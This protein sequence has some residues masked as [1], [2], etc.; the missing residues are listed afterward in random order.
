LRRR[1]IRT[2]PLERGAAVAAALCLS[3]CGSD[4]GKNAVVPPP[5]LPPSVASALAAR[6]DAVADALAAGDSCRAAS[7]AT[8]LQRETIAAINSGRVAG[9]L[10]EPLSTS[11]ND[12][13]A[14][15]RCVPA[16]QP[17][18]EKGRGKHKGRDKKKHKEGD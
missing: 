8:Q 1:K 4:G 9:T 3:A 5:S 13:V 2:K 10:Q 18:D 7:L 6:S 15:V 14:R 11:V 16:P 12:L 17:Q